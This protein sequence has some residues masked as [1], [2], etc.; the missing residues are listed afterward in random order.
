MI[1]LW[2]LSVFR[3][4]CER[5]ILTDPLGLSTF[6]KGWDMVG[7]A[8]RIVRAGTIEGG[9]QTLRWEG[10]L[11]NYC[12]RV[13]HQ[14]NRNHCLCDKNTSLWLPYF[15]ACAFMSIADDSMLI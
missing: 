6:G 8:G 3:S 10:G 7:R 1:H 15:N 13:G 14:F 12:F 2:F 4:E 9:L 11:P 5:E